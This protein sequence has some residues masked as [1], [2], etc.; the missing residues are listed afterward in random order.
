MIVGYCPNSKNVHSLK[1]VKLE[2]FQIQGMFL[3]FQDF[4]SLLSHVNEV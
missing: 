3:K 2:S 1:V 4:K